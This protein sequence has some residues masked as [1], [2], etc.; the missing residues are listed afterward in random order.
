MYGKKRK[1]SPSVVECDDCH[2]IIN[3]KDTALHKEKSCPPNME[4]WVHPFIMDHCLYSTVENIKSSEITQHLPKDSRDDFVF[5]PIHVLQLCG[6]PIGDP[7]IIAPIQSKLAAS[8]VKFAWHLPSKPTDF[9]AIL[10]D[11]VTKL[12]G[13]DPKIH[14]VVSKLEEQIAVADHVVLSYQNDQ[15]SKLDMEEL[16]ER[17]TKQNLNK[18]YQ[19]NNK[20]LVKYYGRQVVFTIEEITSVSNKQSGNKECF[21]VFTPETKLIASHLNSKTESKRCL[22]N[23]LG[24]LND[25]IEE[26]IDTISF[27]MGDKNVLPGLHITRGILVHG[28]MGT[29]KTILIEGLAEYFTKNIVRIECSTIFS[30]IAKETERELQASFE[31]AKV[32]SP[33][34]IL[35]DDLD[36]LCT[37]SNSSSE[38]ERRI[39]ATLTLL[40]DKVNS[41]SGS[42]IVV[43][44]S[45]SKIHLIDSA[46]RSSTRFGKEVEIYVPNS[47][48]RFEILKV[49]MQDIKHNLTDTDVRS[50]ANSSHG[51]VGGDLSSLLS[52]ALLKNYKTSCGQDNISI[53]DF[54]W[55]LG[56]VKPSAMKE[57]TIDIPN[58]KWD[59]IGGQDELK[60]KLKQSVE[61]PL[62]YRDS[63]KRLGITPPKGLLMFGPPGCSKTMIAKALATE[64]R[65]NFICVK[66]PELFNKWV[67]ESERAVRKVFRRARQAAPSI[68]FF[69]ELDAI[70]GERN[71]SSG[72]NVQ[73][74]VLAQMLVELD[75]VESLDSVTVIAATNRLDRIDPAL[76]RPGRL[77]RIVYVP[78]PDAKTRKE[79]FQIQ[80]KKTIA[81]EDVTIEELVD[82]TEGFSGAEIVA[83][84]REAALKALE[85]DFQ[86]EKVTRQHFIE[87]LQIIIPRTP[88]SL[89]DLYN[90]YLS[91]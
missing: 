39:V 91:K 18:I 81:A 54:E 78:L 73:D 34:I 80:L 85:E 50:I 36:V 66:G 77:D 11:E 79:I 55:A 38:H 12:N 4:T 8:I 23:T 37:K 88:K 21:Y 30:K 14:V 6:I 35:L 74:R 31:K 61:W 62:K 58:V 63:F 49:L 64:S 76:L 75:G 19:V 16:L 15:G 1:G 27:I 60:L 13:Y 68:V 45:T 70:G 25:V 52:K 82:R 17:L 10:T 48:Q 83:V 46:L 90:N 57:I 87:A 69:D 3:Q 7:V 71:M 22:L 53:E 44:A 28:P 5:L 2:A 56:K 40:M 20:L 86:A 26:L 32:L 47:N 89:L 41:D 33:S 84:C 51:F 29:G 59:D 42:K 72:S 65:L 67:G 24:G 43:L 9:T